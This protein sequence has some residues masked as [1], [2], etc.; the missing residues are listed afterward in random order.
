MYHNVISANVC[1]ACTI[2]KQTRTLE[3]NIFWDVTPCS[4]LSCNRRFGGTY[5]SKE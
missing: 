5:G 4:V 2:V 3:S 1:T